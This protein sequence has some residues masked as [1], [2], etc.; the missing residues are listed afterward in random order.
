M[1]PGLLQRQVFPK[2]NFILRLTSSNWLLGQACPWADIECHIRREKLDL[3]F[4]VQMVARSSPV[5]CQFMF[6][7]T[8]SSWLIAHALP[9]GKY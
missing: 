2:V 6:R 1:H 9:M 8:S 5:H 4:K 3:E 7:L